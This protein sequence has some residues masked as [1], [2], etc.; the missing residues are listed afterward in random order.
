M[1][2]GHKTPEKSAS[3]KKH[4]LHAFSEGVQLVADIHAIV[5]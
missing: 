1:F 2:Q 4:L 5:K 3:K